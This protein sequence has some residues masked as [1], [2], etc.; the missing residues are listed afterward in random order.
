MNVKVQYVVNL[1]EIPKE[2]QKL[3]PVCE[4]YGDR[5]C[6]LGSLVEE[7]SFS[8]AMDEIESIRES[9]YKVDQRLADCQAILKGYLNVKSRPEERPQEEVPPEQSVEQMVALSESLKQLAERESG[10]QNDPV[11]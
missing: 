6:N 7:Q 11:S 10:A 8:L 5:I 4:N 9:M 1:E 2:V 3:L